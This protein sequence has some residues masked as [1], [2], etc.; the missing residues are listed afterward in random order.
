MRH[1]TLG[2]SALVAFVGT[3]DQKRAKAF[4]QDT[5][6]LE[7]QSEDSF[8]LVFDVDGTTLRVTTV[9]QVAAA[10]YTVLG[11]VVSNIDDAVRDLRA[12][13]ITFE[14]YEGMPQ[15]E[16]GVWRAPSGAHVAWFKDPDGNTLSI[17][18]H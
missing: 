18:Q 15:D 16:R 7:L 4:Y 3:T 10:G 5:L 14:R 9:P 6:G 1:R 17:T 8:A 11:W 13:G 2:G 12:A